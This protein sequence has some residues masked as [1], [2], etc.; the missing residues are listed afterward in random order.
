MND[1]NCAVPEKLKKSFGK[2]FAVGVPTG[3]ITATG[4]HVTQVAVPNGDE[5]PAGGC[6]T[7]LVDNVGAQLMGIEAIHAQPTQ[8]QLPNEPKVSCIP[9]DA[10]SGVLSA[11]NQSLD[12]ALLVE[13]FKNEKPQ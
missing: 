4:V 11:A 1:V 10:V 2:L 12:M 13:L 9:P 8:C 3:P 7:I 5:S 6:M